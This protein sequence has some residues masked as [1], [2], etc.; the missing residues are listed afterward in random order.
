VLSSVPVPLYILYWNCRS[1]PLLALPIRRRQPPTAPLTCTCCGAAPIHPFCLIPFRTRAGALITAATATRTAPTLPLP[2]FVMASRGTPSAKVFPCSYCCMTYGSPANVSRHV[3]ASHRNESRLASMVGRTGMIRM[4]LEAMANAVGPEL[5]PSPAGVP[6]EVPYAATMTL[7]ASELSRAQPPVAAVDVGVAAQMPADGG[8][9]TASAGSHADDGANASE[10]VLQPE[11]VFN[12]T[13]EDMPPPL[14]DDEAEDILDNGCLLAVTDNGES[15]GTCEG[16]Y[17]P[18][19]AA[20]AD[21]RGALPATMPMVQHVFFSST[22]ARIRAYYDA[23]PEVSLSEPVVPRSWATRPSRFTS[24]ALRGALRFAMTAGGCGWTGN[25]HVVYAKTLR[26]VE[27]EA[28]AGTGTVG[29]FTA[30]FRAPHSFLTATRH[31]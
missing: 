14:T 7:G 17:L 18:M 16:E 31:E 4:S 26:A 23:L 10:A 24:P 13:D 27:R 21:L 5:L 8:H 20:V 15:G 29:T 11:A 1:A 6:S 19:D 28:K 2:V 25:D 12:E 3:Q 9:A 22:A 30:A